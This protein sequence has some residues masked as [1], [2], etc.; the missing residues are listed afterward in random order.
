MQFG[1]FSSVGLVHY[2]A[3]QTSLVCTLTPVFT[4]G[5]VREA[6]VQTLLAEFLADVRF[7][8]TASPPLNR[9]TFSFNFGPQILESK[10]N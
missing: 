6:G 3:L 5:K 4:V 8:G 10:K 1:I 9:V 2:R 7:G